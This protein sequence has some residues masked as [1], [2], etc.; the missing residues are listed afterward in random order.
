MEWKCVK[1]LKDRNLIRE[2]EL[3]VGYKFP[4]E[5]IECVLENN[6][7]MP[8]FK[9]FNLNNNVEVFK[10]LKSFNKEDLETIWS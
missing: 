8:E 2:Y 7:G 1:E 5:F 6:G 10:C 9:N 3:Y 4:K